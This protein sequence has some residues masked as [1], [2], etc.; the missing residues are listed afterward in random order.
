MRDHSELTALVRRATELATLTSPT[1][2]ALA[3]DEKEVALANYR[4]IAGI[5]GRTIER[6]RPEQGPASPE[7]LEAVKALLQIARLCT[8]EH[9]R[10]AQADAAQR[11]RSR[12]WGEVHAE[13]EAAQREGRPMRSD[14]S[15]ERR[16]RGEEEIRWPET[17][18]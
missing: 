4:T 10:I 3:G 15:W 18:P 17:A 1:T 7:V 8:N 16:P 6:L 12:R 5:C 2:M 9:D 11:E 14:W 13:F